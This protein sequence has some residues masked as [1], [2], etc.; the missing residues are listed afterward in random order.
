MA[1]YTYPLGSVKIASP[2]SANWDDM[3]GNE[4]SRF[5]GQCDLNVYNL[6]DMTKREAEALINQTEGRLCVRY[7]SRADGTILTRNCPVGLRAMTR[8]VSR[9]ASATLSAILGFLSGLGIYSAMQE[10]H[11]PTTMGVIA[12]PAHE[13]SGSSRRR[14]VNKDALGG[15]A[16][17]PIKK[18]RTRKIKSRATR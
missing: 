4:R 15:L 11:S 18:D 13:N 14:E 17:S 16:A 12:N 5:C 3:I 10:T 9:I 8:R 6:S 7:Y 2:C 1:R